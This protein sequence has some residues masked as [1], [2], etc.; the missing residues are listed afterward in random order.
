[1]A[2]GGHAVFGCQCA[3]PGH[4]G[5]GGAGGEPRGDH[6]PHGPRVQGVLGPAGIQP[7]AGLSQPG[8]RIGLPV[9][10]RA[11]AVHAQLADKGG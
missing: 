6:R 2:L 7:A 5:I 4:I 11:V 3:Q 1:M 9:A 10:V 8:S